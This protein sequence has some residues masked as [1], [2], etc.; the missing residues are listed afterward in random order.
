ME[1]RSRQWWKRYR[2]DFCSPYECAKRGQYHDDYFLF[3]T[4][5]FGGPCD[6]Q[7]ALA[8]HRG[9][10]YCRPRHC[11]PRLSGVSG[12]RP[13]VSPTRVTQNLNPFGLSV[14][15]T[16]AKARRLMEWPLSHQSARILGQEFSAYIPCRQYGTI[17]SVVVTT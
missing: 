9:T 15:P 12:I 7:I 6:R 2:M 10:D 8:H 1:C 14:F 3:R 11:A 5:R 17:A 16:P 13:F 4:I